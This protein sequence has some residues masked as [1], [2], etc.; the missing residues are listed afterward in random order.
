MR[1]IHYFLH[2]DIQVQEL[3]EKKLRE[4]F[5]LVVECKVLWKA[6]VY[7]IILFFFAQDKIRWGWSNIKDNK[8]KMLYTQEYL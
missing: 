7:L 6:I 8:F 3:Y 4:H 5:G 2:Y 1:C